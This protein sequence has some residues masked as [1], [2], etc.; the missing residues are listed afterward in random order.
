MG[1][2]GAASA[3]VPVAG[4]GAAP[5]GAA[6]RQYAIGVDAYAYGPG[7]DE[8]I[9]R[10][11]DSGASR[12]LTG[13]LSLFDGFV[14]TANLRVGGISGHL[15]ATGVG[16]GSI[17]IGGIRVP[18]P[19]LYYVPGL[20]TTLVSVSELVEG[21][22]A[23]T[24]AKVNGV[25][26][27]RLVL[28]GGERA[29]V[30]TQMGLYPCGEVKPGVRALALL[31]CEVEP[32]PLRGFVCVGGKH[33]GNTHV[34]DMSLSELLHKRLGHASWGNT[35]MAAQLRSVF[36]AKVGTG[37]SCAACEACMR[38]KMKEKIS[39]APPSRPAT[40]PLERVHFD[41]S[42]AIL[43]T[44]KGGHKGFALMLDEFTD[45]WFV[46]PLKSK[47]E[48]PAMLRSFRV[49]A[50]KH[51][52]ELLGTVCVPLE[53]AGLRSDGESVNVSGEVAGWCED[54]GITH[55]LSAPYCQWQNGKVERAIQ[56]LWQGSEAMRK[57][58]GAP[59]SMWLWS[60]LAF[61]H[62]RSLL[63]MH[64]EHSSWERWHQVTV[65]LARR[66]AHLRVWGSKCYALVPAQL[67]RKLDD[68]ARVCVFLGY[69][70]RH[71][72][73]VVMDL[74]THRVLVTPHV[75][76]DET[77][78]PFRVARGLGMVPATCL[79]ADM[80]GCWKSFSADTVEPP[81]EPTVHVPLSLRTAGAD[82]GDVA[83]AG[84]VACAGADV[85]VDSGPDASFDDGSPAAVGEGAGTG[86]G[87]A[88]GGA[89]AA[90]DDG[91][92]I[93]AGADDRASDDVFGVPD[94]TPDARTVRRARRAVR[95]WEAAVDDVRA[96]LAMEPLAVAADPY[97]GRAVPESFARAHAAL[98]LEL[99]DAPVRSSSRLATLDELGGASAMLAASPPRRLED[100]VVRVD[101]SIILPQLDPAAPERKRLASRLERGSLSAADLGRMLGRI[102]ILALA[103]AAPTPLLGAKEPTSVPAAV[104]GLNGPAWRAA[105]D[106]EMQAMEEF[107]VWELVPPQPGYTALGCKWIFKIKRDKAGFIEKLKARLTLKG[108]RQVEGRDYD[109]TW[110]PTGRMRVLRAMLAEA[111][112]DPDIKTAQWDCTS[113]FLH[114]QMD[115]VVFMQQ[116]EGYVTPGK[117]GYVCRLLK[118]IYGTKQASKLFH[119]KVRDTLLSLGARVDGLVVHQ[120]VSDD[121]LFVLRRGDAWLK[122]LTHVDD[123]AVTYNDDGLYDAVF[124]VMSADFEITDYDRG[125]I[126]HYV[127]IKVERL[128]DGAYHLSQQAYIEEVLDR[129]GLTDCAHQLSPEATGSGAKLRPIGRV[130]SPSEKEFMAAV[131]YRAAVGALWYVARGT[132]FD[133]FRAVQQLA[134][135][136][137]S[138]GPEHWTALLRVCGYLARTKATPLVLRAAGLTDTVSV[139]GLDLRVVGNSDADWAGDADTSSSHTGWIV[140]FGGALVAWRAE[141]Q[142][143]VSQSSCE[144]EYVAAAALANELVWWRTLAADL[145]YAPA[146]AYPILCDNKAATTLARHS[147]RFEATKHILLRYHVL[148]D[149]QRR[150]FTRALW[151]PAVRQWADVLT[152]NCGVAQFRRVVSHVLGAAV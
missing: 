52:R 43:T 145:G 69:A 7:Q 57:D 19:R 149:Y 114:A 119:D 76:F 113:A 124:A 146:G 56:T 84:S 148:R 63:P 126:G 66:L 14:R 72:A 12:H 64:G 49:A 108:Y 38:A 29:V 37:L 18:L 46:W 116:P 6:V 111:S 144:A 35:T 137:A 62:T 54:L 103:A 98:C 34:G 106:K 136:V 81:A 42:P 26:A 152:K 21:G 20:T 75:V 109:E 105:M 107:G 67:R 96:A 59:P 78:F 123:F 51:F 110:A 13:D 16:P 24:F 8:C 79:E 5:V 32:S 99:V 39:R 90:A 60:L 15:T 77:R 71:K 143:S 74:V 88:A 135:Y 55:E 73:Y 45:Q 58:A 127:G 50:E 30:P 80:E 53:L 68:K 10:V 134:R 97:E 151:V 125:P 104:S 132:R 47:S 100:A 112:S 17:G 11:V 120:A 130:L 86:A 121:C 117:E 140:R 70:D 129:L 33:V 1:G 87:V 3:P 4:A 65:P 115:K 61:A 139:D 128:E 89:A 93:G 91:A 25:H 44:S 147:G 31:E 133:I 2:G 118:A 142:G 122:V 9:G 23:V 92:G 22:G 48:I 138:P 102:E 141:I 36:G 28:S 131:P 101:G 85:C 82:A 41:L 95:I 27:M 83:G 150:G 40:R 94:V